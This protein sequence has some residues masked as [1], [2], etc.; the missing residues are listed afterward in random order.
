MVPD[1]ELAVNLT[2]EASEVI[3]SLN[4]FQPQLWGL[5]AFEAS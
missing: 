2:K 4:A 1:P 3:S 5:P